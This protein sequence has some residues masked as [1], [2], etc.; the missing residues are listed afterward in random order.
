MVALSSCRHI[1]N[2]PIDGGHASRYQRKIVLDEGIPDESFIVFDAYGPD[3]LGGVGD[4]D[5]Y[6][7]FRTVEGTWS[8]PF[9]LEEI[10]T[11]STN[12]TASLSPDGRFLFFYAN[13]DIY[14][15]SADIL[16]P[17]LSA[18]QRTP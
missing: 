1:L 6:I 12:M 9:H 5:F 8:E 3:A 7:S 13:H 11:A 15:V 16:Q 14:W 18:F 4:D 2:I 10:S 17:Y